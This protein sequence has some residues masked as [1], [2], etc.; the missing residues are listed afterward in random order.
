[1]C[2]MISVFELLPA[3]SWERKLND[4]AVPSPLM[5]RLNE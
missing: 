2:D 5:R 4:F 3:C 1:M